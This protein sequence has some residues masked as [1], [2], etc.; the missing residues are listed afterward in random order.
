MTGSMKREIGITLT[1]IFV[2]QGHYAQE[3]TRL[4]GDPM[5]DIAIDH[6]EELRSLALAELLAAAG[7]AATPREPS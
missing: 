7:P 1:T 5:P 3:Q 2:R 4:P 6:I